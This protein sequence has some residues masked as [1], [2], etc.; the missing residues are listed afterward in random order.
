MEHRVGT[1]SDIGNR[2]G[3]DTGDEQGHEGRHRKVD[4]QHLDGEHQAGN[5]GLEDTRDGTCRTTSYEEHHRACIDTE[6]ASQIGTDGRTREHDRCLGT[7]RTTEADGDGAG[8]NRRIHI[9][10]TYAGLLTRDGIENLGHAMPDIVAH[11]VADKQPRKEDT[12]HRIDEVEVVG[13][14]GVE[15]LCEEVLDEVDEI[16]QRERCKGRAEA[17]EHCEDK[18]KSLGTDVLF[19]PLGEAH[20]PRCI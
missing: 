3:G 4:K 10:R 18:R 14:V 1:R 6:Q 2:S 19:A 11:N 5:G 8:N 17:H 12:Y 20:K 15:I 9:V 13:L 16:L 7:H